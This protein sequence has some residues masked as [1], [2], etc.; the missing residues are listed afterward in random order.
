MGAPPRRRPERRPAI[1]DAAFQHFAQYGFRRASMGEIARGAGLSRAA[2]YL[3]FPTK[4]ALFRA[5]VQDLHARALASATAR[6]ATDVGLETGVLAILEE[7]SLRLF[8]V[9]RTTAHAAEFLDENDRLCGDLAAQAARGYGT[10]LA[11]V[12]AAADRRGELALARQHLRPD[13]AAELLLAAAEGLKA[14]SL[15]TLTPAQFRRR[16]AQLVHVLLSGLAR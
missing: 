11:R 1:L 12:L 6:A 8:E 7:K 16:L 15:A 9:L 10:L 3:H 5:L 14:R 13:G 4:E 2:L